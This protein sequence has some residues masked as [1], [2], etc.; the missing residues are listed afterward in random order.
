MV[1]PKKRA[2]G[3]KKR[4][5]QQ[6]IMDAE[7]KAAATFSFDRIV[8]ALEKTKM[9]ISALEENRRK[10]SNQTDIEIKVIRVKLNRYKRYLQH[11]KESLK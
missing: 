2:S 10:F 11:K 9:E 7:K 3:A 5:P 8:V 6:Q 4:T 1:N